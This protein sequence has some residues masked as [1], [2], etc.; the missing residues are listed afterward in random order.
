MDRRTL[1]FN[2]IKINMKHIETYRIF[3]S[4]HL[5]KKRNN[6][7]IIDTIKDLLLDIQDDD[8]KLNCGFIAKSDSNRGYIYIDIGE[9]LLRQNNISFSEYKNQLEDLR[10]FLKSE[11]F[12]FDSFS[13]LLLGYDIKHSYQ[14]EYLYPNLEIKQRDDMLFNQEL[15]KL[16]TNWLRI[17][18]KK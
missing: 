10:F 2:K 15:V 4:N 9:K 18:F 11:G 1:P 3:E 14:L 12:N 17:I 16:E 7:Y 13:W 5:I 6:D 8:I